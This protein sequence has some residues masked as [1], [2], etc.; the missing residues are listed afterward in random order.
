MAGSQAN[1]LYKSGT[2]RRCDCNGRIVLYITPFS[3]L[4]FTA[5]SNMLKL[6]LIY[7]AKGTKQEGN[8]LLHNATCF[9]INDVFL[10]VCNLW[11]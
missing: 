9:Y 7:K 8:L 11:E 6:C 10:R 3:L 2:P 5:Q 4:M 1:T